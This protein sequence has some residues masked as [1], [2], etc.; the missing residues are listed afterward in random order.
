[1]TEEWGEGKGR[2]ATIG[3]HYPAA[4]FGA[5]WPVVER[6]FNSARVISRIISEKEMD[7]SQCNKRR[8]LSALP[9]SPRDSA[10]RIRR[11]F[12]FRYGSDSSPTVRKAIS[13]M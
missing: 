6:E 10:G 11:G 9:I 7:G 1:M 2:G 4:R 12:A 8:A 13:T 3:F 5:T